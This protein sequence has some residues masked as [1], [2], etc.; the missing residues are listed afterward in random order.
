MV[1]RPLTNASVGKPGSSNRPASPAWT[2]VAGTQLQRADSYWLISQPDHAQLAGD[3]A[4]KF[5]SPAFPKLEPEV[6]QAIAL[7][8]AGW[9]NLEAEKNPAS[10]PSLNSA[11]RP[12]AFFEL[13]PPDFV[14]AWQASIDSAEKASPIAGL[15]VSGHFCRLAGE[16]TR[17]HN[18][19]AQDAFL[20]REFLRGEALRRDRLIDRQMR[21]WPK[22]ER[23]VD[24]LQ[25]CDLVSLYLCCGLAEPVEFP[26]TF[27]GKPVRAQL[28]GGTYVFDPSPFCAPGAKVAPIKLSVRATRYPA[29]KA[30]AG[31][32]VLPLLVR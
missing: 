23:L 3:L 1:L 30:G 29:V 18:D 12:L 14:R 6:V 16:R 5:C 15:M 2:A 9:A 13:T 4:A 28:A 27:G 31:S 32:S 19:S 26:Q 22:I 10:K 11:G 17:T 21:T 25:F 7:H 20:L 8:D 24:V